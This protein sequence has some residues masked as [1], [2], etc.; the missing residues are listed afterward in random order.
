[1]HL[2]GPVICL[3]LW[4]CGVGGRCG[5]AASYSI[6]LSII[7]ALS[8]GKL[9]PRSILLYCL[10]NVALACAERISEVGSLREKNLD[11]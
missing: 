8:V 9:A 10:K 3:G 5:D 1:M 2:T 7:V 11:C 6:M 4:V